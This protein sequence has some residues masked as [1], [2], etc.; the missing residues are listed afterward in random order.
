VLKFQTPNV[1]HDMN[2]FAKFLKDRD[3]IDLDN[4]TISSKDNATKAEFIVFSS[5][6]QKYKLKKHIKLSLKSGWS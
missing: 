1:I 5:K 3:G 4:D 6:S 2:I